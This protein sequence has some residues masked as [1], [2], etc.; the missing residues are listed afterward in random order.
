MTTTRIYSVF[1]SEV[2]VTHLVRAATKAQAVNHVV[3]SRF[4]ANVAT[5][6]ELILLMSNGV[7]VEDSTAVEP[8]SQDTGTMNVTTAPIT[9]PAPLPT[10]AQS[11]ILQPE[12]QACANTSE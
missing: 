2:G 8:P 9:E 3:R 4:E 5:Q 7:R 10:Q 11:F 6:E 12:A 1:D